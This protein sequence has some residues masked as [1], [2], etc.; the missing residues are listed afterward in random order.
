MDE[1]QCAKDKVTVVIPVYNEERFLRQ[2]LESVVDQVDCVVIGDNASTDGTEAICREFAEKYPHVRYFRNEENL[3]S[4]ENCIRCCQLVE[5]E[6]MF[7]VGGHDLIPPNYVAE[8]KTT[9]LNNPD[10]VCAHGNCSWLGLDG[11]VSKTC[12]FASVRTGM[13]DDDPYVRA[14]SFFCEKQRCDLIFGLY[15]SDSALPIFAELK[16]IL[17]CDYFILVAALLDGKF[18]YTPKTTYLRRMVHP[19]DTTRDSME[20]L[21]GNHASKLFH[22]YDDI[23]KQILDRVWEHRNRA[24]LSREQEKAFRALLFQ[25]ALK[26]DTPVDCP[27]WDSVFSLRKWWRKWCKTIKCRLIPGYAKRKGRR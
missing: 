22:D 8:L 12:D 21:A 14:A 5:T 16:P 1:K 10:A 20:R 25:I 9:L 6:F 17:C 23:G 11:T 26:L 2:A 4:V 3:G 7:H 15:R 19:K 13:L 24:T 27:F 18:V